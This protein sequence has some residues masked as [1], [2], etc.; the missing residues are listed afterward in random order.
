M[1]SANSI[2]NAKRY[3][4]MREMQKR[5]RVD[6]NGRIIV[7]MTVNDDGDFLSRFSESEN[8]VINSDV[9]DFIENTTK[10]IPP[11]AMISL[12]IHSDCIDDKEK[13]VYDK[14]IREYY[15]E[16]YISADK[17]RKRNLLISAIMLFFGVLILSTA[18]MLEYANNIIWSEVI[19]IVA[20]VL[21][22]EATDVI[23]FKNR[24]LKLQ[25][26]RALTYISMNIEYH[27]L[28]KQTYSSVNQI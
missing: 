5:M 10:S 21:I 25:R 6:T 23:F 19:D 11:S 12:R 22:W 3:A 7:D 9:A 14:A 17:E 24:A 20:W 16:K 8:P 26:L 13:V 15:T 1:N 28:Q 2:S 27:P 18:I 4:D